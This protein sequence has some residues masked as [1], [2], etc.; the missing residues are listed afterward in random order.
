MKN[1]SKVKVKHKPG[2]KLWVGKNSLTSLHSATDKGDTG[3][4]TLTLHKKT[5]CSCPE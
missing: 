1:K 2:Q 4:K 5:I 3:S